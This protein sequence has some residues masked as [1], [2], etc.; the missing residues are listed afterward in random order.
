MADEEP[1]DERPAGD[2]PGGEEH[3]TRR[4]IRRRRPGADDGPG[5]AGPVP[6]PPG[7]PAD[8]VA[9]SSGAAEPSPSRLAGTARP[10][11][12]EDRPADRPV[13]SPRRRE[14][15]ERSLR[16]LVAAGPTQVSVANAMRAR[17]AARPAAE[18]LAAA[19]RELV[20]VRRYYVPPDTRPPE[21]S[22]SRAASIA[23][24]GT[25]QDS[26]DSS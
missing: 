4:R 26:T 22:G 17:D 10:D 16:G 3:G 18:D 7:T 23:E 24:R 6:A 12:P 8:A 21:P 1:V 14:P 19:E 13:G 25:G 11:L 20:I 9:A 5:R 15:G 2:L